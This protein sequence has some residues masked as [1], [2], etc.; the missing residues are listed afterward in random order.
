[1][2]QR[3]AHLVPALAVLDQMH[4]LPDV[5]A[6]GARPSAEAD[7]VVA[8]RGAG[9]R[10]GRAVWAAVLDRGVLLPVLVVVVLL[11]HVERHLR[12]GVV[13]LPAA[14]R[15]LRSMHAAPEVEHPVHTVGGSA[16]DP[17]HV[18]Q[19]VAGVGEV[20]VPADALVVVVV[21]AFGVLARQGLVA[22]AALPVLD[23]AEV[24]RRGRGGAAAPGQGLPGDLA[25]GER[26]VHACAVCAGLRVG[27]AQHVVVP[28]RMVGAPH[29]ILPHLHRH[30]A[31]HGRR[32]GAGGP[33]LRNR[34]CGTARAR[35]RTWGGGPSVQQM[36]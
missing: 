8:D 30:D 26:P 16:G 23:Q 4:P 9:Q 1:M 18:A 19:H 31:R 35:A 25:E 2:R 21:G 20:L 34:R 11:H 24:R 12:P 5:G 32:G 7:R 3:P 29:G 27:V 28:G 15:V 36:A 6:L 33:A 22:P 13:A 17:L 10:A 14:V